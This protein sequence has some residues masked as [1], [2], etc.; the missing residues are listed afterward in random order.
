MQDNAS[1][2]AYGNDIFRSFASVYMVETSSYSLGNTAVVDMSNNH[3]G[4]QSDPDALNWRIYDFTDDPNIHVT[5]DY[6][7]I[8][9]APVPTESMNWGDVKSMYR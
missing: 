5:V 8:E 2:I 4:D 1:L 7:P 6:M 9:G 3:W